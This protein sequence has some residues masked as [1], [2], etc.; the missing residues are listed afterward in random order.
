MTI[1]FLL[2]KDIFHNHIDDREKFHESLENGGQMTEVFWE[3]LNFTYH[4]RFS[5]RETAL[6]LCQPRTHFIFWKGWEICLVSPENSDRELLKT[7]ATEAR[8]KGAFSLVLQNIQLGI[9]WKLVS[10]LIDTQGTTTQCLFPIP[11]FLR[12]PGLLITGNFVLSDIQVLGVSPSSDTL[13]IW[14]FLLNFSSLVKRLI[15]C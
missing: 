2:K 12:A 6:V 9:Q 1:F 7:W 8:N 4:D 11:P 5:I 14:H 13:E 15:H 3:A 10:T